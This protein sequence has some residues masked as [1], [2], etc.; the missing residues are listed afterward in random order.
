MKFAGTWVD[1]ATY[2]QLVAA[3]RNGIVNPLVAR[4]EARRVGLDFALACAVLEQES[5][6][7]HNIFGH[8]P[9]IWA[10]GGEVTE[11]KYLAYKHQRQASG[12]RLMQGVG[13][14]QLTWWSTQD[15]ADAYGGCWNVR[16]NMRV[17]F[18]TLASNVH[19]YGLWSGVRAYNG[20]GP[21]ADNYAN[22][23]MARYKKWQ[24]ILG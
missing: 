18:E 21:A 11:S 24:G 9:T 23:V 22:T 19:R 16:F 1:P 12:N 6:G 3:K 10:G 2:K 5:A 15:R 13:P 17:G 20:S 7:G 14:M 4:Q 8:D